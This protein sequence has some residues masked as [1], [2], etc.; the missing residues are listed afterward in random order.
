MSTP[1]YKH[2]VERLEATPQATIHLGLD[3]MRQAVLAED[4]MRPAPTIVTVAGTNG[5]GTVA[6]ALSQL[7]TQRGWKTTLLT[8]PHLVDVRERIRI[9]GAPIGRDAL[10][11]LGDPLLRRYG[12]ESTNTP[13]PL[14]YF[15]L[16]VLLGLRAAKN[17]QSD[18]LIMEVGL[19]GQFDATNVLDADVSV[20]ASISLDHTDL[21]GDTV[22]AIAY[23][24]S[25]V[26][27][28]GNVAVYHPALSGASVLSSLLA[29]LG[30]VQVQAEGGHDA[31][32]RNLALAAQTFGV[33]EQRAEA[34]SS[35]AFVMQVLDDFQ[36][37]GRQTWTH[38]PTG[39]PVLLDGAHNP[40]SAQELADTLA[41]HP[42][43]SLMPAVISVSGG[44][45]VSQIIAPLAPY[46]RTWHVCKPPFERSMPAVNLAEQILA[47]EAEHQYG[48]SRHVVIHTDVA[49][50]LRA[51]ERECR[52]QHLASVLAF[53][54]LYL[55]AEIYTQW[56]P[57]NDQVL[58]LSRRQSRLA[59]SVHPDASRLET[60][61]SPVALSAPHQRGKHAA[62]TG[63]SAFLHGDWFPDDPAPTFSEKHIAFPRAMATAAAFSAIIL[64]TIA[65]LA[66]PA[67]APIYGRLSVGTIVGNA[68]PA[69]F[70]FT[71]FK[72]S[73]DV[74]RP[75]AG[76]IGRA[77]L[78]GVMF[79]LAGTFLTALLHEVYTEI[80]SG[81][82]AE[83]WWKSL[84]AAR[85]ASYSDLLQPKGVPAMIAAIT[86]VA[87]APG[88]FEEFLFRGAIYRVMER[89][90][91]WRRILFVGALFSFIHFDVVGFVPLLL[92]GVLLTWLRALSGSWIYSAIVHF[93]FNL[94][95]LA[96]SM[97]GARAE[98]IADTG[99][100]NAEDLG[101]MPL[102]VLV[103]FSGAFAWYL[104]KEFG[105]KLML[106][107][108]SSS[109]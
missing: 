2:F 61:P 59:A 13:R 26:A 78:M 44:R 88:V 50:A 67:G 23:E 76:F 11:A 63:L 104:F 72:L 12:A 45:D 37:P 99:V 6:A 64:M 107:E 62:K 16:N 86:A 66:L 69:I 93:A 89:V 49:Q 71:A 7:C 80:L 60:T 75:K 4:L 98:E 19:G 95:A 82:F 103:A 39:T 36:W 102:V 32:T 56:W 105:Q 108:K 5:K 65:S 94:T 55:I 85:E 109:M 100:Q 46:V 30:A 40:A 24:K 83:Q 52:E 21:L 27:R 84:M 28:A 34:T 41:K 57:D 25:R 9:N 96:L 17:A 74:R 18:V 101:W 3:V 33:L 70:L 29:S 81:T 43:R 51:A 91:V 68:L 14:S 20:F 38:S 42:P 106:S 35:K 77:L 47:W 54:S 92:L 58:A 10:Q 1:T 73:W 31:R 87:V 15:E 22:E 8:S 97:L 90:V 79:S 48:A 53:G